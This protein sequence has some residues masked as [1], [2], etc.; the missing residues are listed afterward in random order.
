MSLIKAAGIR[1]P[2]QPARASIFT[3]L[4]FNEFFDQ[5]TTTR[6]RDLFLDDFVEGFA[7][8]NV[9]IPPHRSP[10]VLERAG[11]PLCY[12]RIFSGVA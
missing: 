8:R 6:R 5:R 1:I 9:A 3:H 7:G 12:W 11:Q 10:L 4:L 2:A